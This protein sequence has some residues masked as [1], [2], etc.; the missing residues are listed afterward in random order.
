M[1]FSAGSTRVGPEFGRAPSALWQ[2]GSVNGEADDYAE[3]VLDLIT[4]IP[5]GRVST[6]GA[7]AELAREVTGKG[8]PRSIGRVLSRFGSGVPWWRVCAAGG[9]L[10]V[11]KAD[12]QK[13]L[14]REENV[15]FTASGRVRISEVGWPQEAEPP[16]RTPNG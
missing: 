15:P 13:A 4:Q 2:H 3:Q 8:G 14:L 16:G 9:R 12:E 11:H 10:A 5:P 1:S 6:Y 7:I